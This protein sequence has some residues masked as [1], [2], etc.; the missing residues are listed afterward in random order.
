MLVVLHQTQTFNITINFKIV[1]VGITALVPPE[2]IYAHGHSCIDVNNLVPYSHLKPK[3]KLCAWT[4]IWREMIIRKE[5]ELDSLVVVASGDCYNSVVEGEK[6][7]SFGYPVTYFFYPFD[8]NKKEMEK[9]IEKLSLFLGKKRN[10]QAYEKIYELKGKAIELDEK[11]W[12]GEIWGKELFPLLISFSDLGGDIDA[13]QRK[14][15]E[16][17]YGDEVE[18]I[19]IALLGV[20]PIYYDFHEVAEHIGFHIVFDELAYEFIR[21]R[22][23]NEREIAHNY[24]SYSFARNITHRIRLLKKELRRRKIEGIIHYT[25]FPCHHILEDEILR[26]E[27]PYLMLTIQGDLP[28]KTPEQIKLRLEAFYEMLEEK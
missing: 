4:A 23:R 11:R 21:L 20:P 17:D 16:F 27:L 19:P 15:E 13:L 26:K 8:G 22:G 12:K 25:Q 7:S 1:K 18:G 9:E 28:Q 24:A 2:V 10:E 3:V 14:I 5:I 6:I